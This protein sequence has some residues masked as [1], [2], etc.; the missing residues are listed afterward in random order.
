MLLY[1]QISI[2]NQIGI[3]HITIMMYK[4]RNKLFEQRMITSYTFMNFFFHSLF[5]VL[6]A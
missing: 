4:L 1:R 3:T 2:L 5:S 6:I